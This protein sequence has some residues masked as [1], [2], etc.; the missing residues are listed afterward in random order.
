[1][2]IRK[3]YVPAAAAVAPQLAA[4]STYVYVCR[5]YCFC[6]VFGF[7]FFVSELCLALNLAVLHWKRLPSMWRRAFCTGDAVVDSVFT[8]TQRRTHTTVSLGAVH[9]YRRQSES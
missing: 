1:M 2:F 3:N 8:N 7:G 4:F 5:M 9:Y 6:F